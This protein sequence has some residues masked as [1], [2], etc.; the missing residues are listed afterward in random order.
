MF[1]KSKFGYNEQ[2]GS[3]AIRVQAGI[4]HEIFESVNKLAR[5]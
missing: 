2:N 3:P 5:E 4:Y 1:P